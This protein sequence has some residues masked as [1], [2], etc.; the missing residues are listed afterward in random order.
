MTNKPNGAALPSDTYLAERVAKIRTIGRRA[1]ADN[2]LLGR[3]MWECRER[4]QRGQWT[5]FCELY[6]EVHVQTVNRFIRGFEFSETPRGKELVGL[7]SSWFVLTMLAAASED[8]IDAIVAHA[9]EFASVPKAPIV[10]SLLRSARPNHKA[11]KLQAPRSRADMQSELAGAIAKDALQPIKRWLRDDC[12][13]ANFCELGEA[14]IELITAEV[15]RRRNIVELPA[16]EQLPLAIA[17][18]QHAA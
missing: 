10:A 18:P 11:D 8:K 3:L 6:F 13:R 12:P 4:I 16:P 5:N 2:L 1:L 17:E 14:A 15:S 9:R 7:G